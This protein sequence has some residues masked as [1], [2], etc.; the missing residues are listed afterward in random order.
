MF[1]LLSLDRGQFGRTHSDFGERACGY[2]GLC[3][4]ELLLSPEGMV[5]REDRPV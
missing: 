2:R 4:F 5:A 3:L 1:H